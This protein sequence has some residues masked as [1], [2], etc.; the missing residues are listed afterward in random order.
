MNQFVH[1]F[2]SRPK[3]ME[4]QTLNLFISPNFTKNIH[5]LFFPNLKMHTYLA[6]LKSG[7]LESALKL[8]VD[9]LMQFIEQFS[10]MKGTTEL[11]TVEQPRGNFQNIELSKKS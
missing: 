4:C 3:N 2:M 1:D 9:F 11:H 5:N 8:N 7:L 6:Y 10:C